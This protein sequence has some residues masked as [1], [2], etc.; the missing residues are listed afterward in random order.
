MKSEPGSWK[1]PFGSVSA[2][3][4]S[5]S[6]KISQKD[7][8]GANMNTEIVLLFWP[9]R[10]P[11]ITHF[12]SPRAKQAPNVSTNYNYNE[13]IICKHKGVWVWKSMRLYF[14]KLCID[15]FGVH[16]DCVV[17]SYFQYCSRDH[18]VLGIEPR[19]PAHK[20]YAQLTEEAH[21]GSSLL[22]L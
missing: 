2:R 6:S 5:C 21:E 17:R 13:Q 14:E 3:I 19:L 8:L 15:C 1:A 11:F 12:H 9:R 16:I 20:A 4:F 22:N 7:V 10:Y 18:A